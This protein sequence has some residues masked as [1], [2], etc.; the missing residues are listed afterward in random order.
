MNDLAVGINKRLLVY[1]THAFQIA[2]VK[3]T[4]R[5][6]VAGMSRFNFTAGHITSCLRSSAAICA[7]L[8]TKPSFA[9]LASSALKRSFKFSSLCRSQI[10]RT[11]LPETNTLRLRHA[12]RVRC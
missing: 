5:S 12:L 11:P 6:Q 1:T 8:S 4:L 10:E 3:G 7:S 9:T 2:Y